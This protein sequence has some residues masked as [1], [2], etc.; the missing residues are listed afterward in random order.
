MSE[1][2]KS[3]TGF[4]GLVQ[5]SDGHHVGRRS[6]SFRTSPRVADAVRRLRSE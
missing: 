1:T 5:W 6:A 2:T 4:A 3:T